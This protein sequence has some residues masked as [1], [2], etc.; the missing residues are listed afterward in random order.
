MRAAALSLLLVSAAQSAVAQDI[1]YLPRCVAQAVQQCD[2]AL[3]A[4]QGYLDAVQ[5]RGADKM[6]DVATTVD[7]QAQV[8]SVLEAIDMN[9]GAG[10]IEQVTFGNAANGPFILCSVMCTGYDRADAAGMNAI[11]T[12]ALAK[13][14]PDAHVVGGSLPHSVQAQMNN[15]SGNYLYIVTGWASDPD[16]IMHATAWDGE[17]QLSAVGLPSTD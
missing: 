6:I 10:I 17:I 2:A 7:N 9:A 1:A 16:L 15:L 3:T 8:V 14:A 4:P 11:L 13:A 12:E 5:S